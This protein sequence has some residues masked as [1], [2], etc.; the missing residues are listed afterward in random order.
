MM[1]G[2]IFR[3]LRVYERNYAIT[4][5]GAFGGSTCWFELWAPGKF[6]AAHCDFAYM[7]SPKSFADIFLP[8]IE[9]QTQYLDY[10]VFHVDG[11]GSFAHVDALVELP[12][13]QAIQILPG[14]GKPSPL[15][16]LDVLRKVQNAGKNLHISIPAEEVKDAIELLSA[17]GLFID[18]SCKSEEEAKNLLHKVEQWSVDRN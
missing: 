4:R 12:H 13:L 2:I 1:Q 11:I 3:K 6:Y 10:C 8:V 5:E 16:Y 17:R 7:I 18:T 15:H 14:A 9:K